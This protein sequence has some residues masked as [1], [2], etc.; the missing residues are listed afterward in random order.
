M[1]NAMRLA[2]GTTTDLDV[3]VAF[4]LVHDV[5]RVDDSPDRWHGPRARVFASML[6]LMR[7]LLNES[8][9][10]MLAVACERHSRGDTTTEA[11]IGAC[12]DAD[13]LDLV[14]IN[15][16]PR[17][18]LMSTTRGREEAERLAKSERTWRR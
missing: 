2:I 1:T 14:R 3:V 17:V 5:S 12:W 6:D 4:A 8:Q 13:R 18:S 11:T 9:R 16:L 15:V 10:E 7:T